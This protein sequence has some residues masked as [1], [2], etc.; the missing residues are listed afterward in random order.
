MRSNCGTGTD[1]G[2][3]LRRS[4]VPA[5][6]N[7]VGMPRYMIENLEA[8]VQDLD[9]Y[10]IGVMMATLIQLQGVVSAQAA[11]VLQ[12]RQAEVRRAAKARAR[13]DDQAYADWQA[14]DD[15]AHSLMQRSATLVSCEDGISTFG[16]WLQ[17]LSDAFMGMDA[18]KQGLC[19]DI[20]RGYLVGRYGTGMGRA[21]MG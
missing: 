15:D 16:F 2:S 6:N 12:D 3:S 5:D 4:S 10:E 19:A 1:T 8:A 21:A 7:A 11:Q 13:E 20:L 14:W 18:T 17:K 9:S